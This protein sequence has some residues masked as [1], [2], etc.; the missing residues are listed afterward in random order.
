MLLVSGGPVPSALTSIGVRIHVVGSSPLRPAV[1]L[2]FAPSSAGAGPV[3][4]TWD[5]A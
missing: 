5:V 1:P 4:V 3:L 2:G